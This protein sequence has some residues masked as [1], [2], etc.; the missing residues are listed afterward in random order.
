[1]YV[2]VCVF[3]MYFNS[4]YILIFIIIILHN[5]YSFIIYLFYLPVLFLCSILQLHVRCWDHFPSASSFFFNRFILYIYAG[6]L[7]ED[8]LFV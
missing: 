7:M 8:S 3:L 6:L 5:R 2:G 1:M 4:I